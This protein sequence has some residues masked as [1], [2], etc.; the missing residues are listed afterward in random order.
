MGHTAGKSGET[1][2][3]EYARLLLAQ[4]AL[5]AALAPEITAK[6]K[7]ISEFTEDFNSQL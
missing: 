3:G 5:E 7:A 2:G 6:L 4:E 1:Y